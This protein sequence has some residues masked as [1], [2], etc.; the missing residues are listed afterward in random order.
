MNHESPSVFSSTLE[1]RGLLSGCMQM[2]TPHESSLCVSLPPT[3]AC[4]V[5]LS[6]LSIKRLFRRV[7][8]SHCES[9]STSHKPCLVRGL[10]DV[11]FVA[12]FC[13]FENQYKDD[14]IEIIGE[15]PWVALGPNATTEGG[16]YARTQALFSLDD[17]GICAVWVAHCFGVFPRSDA[18]LLHVPADAHGRGWRS[19]Q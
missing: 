11:L 14:A 4:F 19:P 5:L 1:K 18:D 6:H 12:M 9:R 2:Q 17:P 7:A 10:N 15:D 13:D 8:Q 16:F 3:L